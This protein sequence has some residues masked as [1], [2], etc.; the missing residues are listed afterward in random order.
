MPPGVG[1]QAASKIART[2]KSIP[3]NVRIRDYPYYAKIHHKDTECT[4]KGIALY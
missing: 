1:P 4:K 2:L 3:K